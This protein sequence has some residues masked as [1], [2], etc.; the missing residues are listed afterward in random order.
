[1]RGLRSLLRERLVMEFSGP[2]GVEP[3]VE[4]I[5]PPKLETRL[6]KR[7]VAIL[8]TRVAFG[9]ISGVGG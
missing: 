3:E 6:R 4:L 7:I 1:M 5:L 2:D 9:Q 8:R